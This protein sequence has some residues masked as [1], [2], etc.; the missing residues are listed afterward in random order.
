MDPSGS[1]TS[2]DHRWTQETYS[3]FRDRIR[4]H[5]AEMLAA[6]KETDPEESGRSR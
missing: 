2:F 6:Y 1:G 5:A 4:V 3:Y